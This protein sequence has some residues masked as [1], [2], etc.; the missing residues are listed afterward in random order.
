MAVSENEDGQAIF[1]VLVFLP[2][3]IFLFTIIFN[4]GSA[5]NVSINQQQSVRRYFYYLAKGNSYMPNQRNMQKY[6][7]A[8]YT[9]IG[10]SIIGLRQKEVPGVG[11]T[12]SC[13]KFSSFITGSSD[14]ECEDPPDLSE[15]PPSTNYI[16]IFTG[17]GI[18]GDTYKLI[19]SPHPHWE[20]YFT[21]DPG[22][23]DPRSNGA[24]CSMQH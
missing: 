6:L 14:E 11:S 23:L 5:I 8:P 7:K 22:E 21:N 19:D 13:F 15:S 16:R 2:L 24:N 4:V 3:F 17:Y 12:G 20:S 9:R 10:M 1:E 18:C